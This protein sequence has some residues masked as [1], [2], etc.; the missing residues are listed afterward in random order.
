MSTVDEG[1]RLALPVISTTGDTFMLF[2]TKHLS[3]K[4]HTNM[5]RFHSRFEVVVTSGDD[6][7]LRF[8]RMQ[9][10]KIQTSSR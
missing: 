5:R 4:L 3:I 2:M 9:Q 1:L 8:V 10:V 7:S 6:L